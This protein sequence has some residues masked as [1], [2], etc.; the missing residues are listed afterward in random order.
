MRT[1][2][3]KSSSS[4][5]LTEGYVRSQLPASLSEGH[6][7]HYCSINVSLMS[8]SPLS[9]NI[10][11]R[12]TYGLTASKYTTVY[13]SPLSSR[14]CRRSLSL[15][16]KCPD[17]GSMTN[18]R[19]RLRYTK[20]R[21]L[22]GVMDGQVLN[23]AMLAMPRLR[24]IMV[25]FSCHAVHGLSWETLT[26]ILSV[27]QL[28]NFNIQLFNFS[29]RPR[30]AP[31]VDARS[32]APLKSFRYI[33][34][35]F[36][37]WPHY[38]PPE[39]DALADVLGQLHDSLEILHLPSMSAP[40]NALAV[41]PW[42]RLR[43]LVL[44]GQLPQGLR[45]PF[46]TLLSGMPKLLVLRLLFALP[47]G[48]DRL[49]IWPQGVVTSFPWPE[50]EELSLSFPPPE[51]Q[52]YAFLPE[53]LRRLSLR[54]C[55]HHCVRERVDRPVWH[56]PIL[57][58]SEMLQILSR[59]PLPH[60]DHL[61]LEYLADDADGPLL[62]HVTTAFPGLLTLEVHRFRPEG[63]DEIPVVRWIFFF[64]SRPAFSS[65]S[66]DPP[67]PLCRLRLAKSLDR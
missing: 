22:C 44:Q 60:L 15:V 24:S 43:E 41:E 50:L 49:P 56:S 26:S 28:E 39:R 36:R 57:S 13:R 62:R 27:P 32:L 5:A 47:P 34:P 51:D 65:D 11:S 25:S 7:S 64:S 12:P 23:T 3:S 46:I 16:D 9:L 52:I 66:A 17:I 53:S 6:A 29:P 10:F 19:R 31:D 38:F 8:T 35:A 59:S 55:P 42:P 33:Q 63:V 21:L 67:P 1:S 14:G 30:P 37:W 18:M 4:Y 45:S 54:C 40:I 48:V 61:Q 20:D 58:A 2:S